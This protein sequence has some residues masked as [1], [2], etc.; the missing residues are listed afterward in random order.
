MPLT[1]NVQVEQNGVVVSARTLTNAKP[2]DV[3][4]VNGNGDQLTGFDASRPAAATVV[5]VNATASSGVLL[6]ANANRRQFIVYNDSGRNI[7]IAFAATASAAAYTVRISN[8]GSYESPK[9]GYT[10]VVSVV[11]QSGTGAVLVTEVT[12]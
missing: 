7:Y 4:V 5:S 2:V 6:A 10:G 9:D 8:Q 12:T 1:G 11:T 3:A